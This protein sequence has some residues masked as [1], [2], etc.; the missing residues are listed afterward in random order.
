M[1]DRLAEAVKNLKGKVLISYDDHPDVKKA[2]KGSHWKIEK[3][4]IKYGFETIKPGEKHREEDEL[5]IRN[6]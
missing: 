4:K 1:F 3:V 2:F 5:L 6:Y